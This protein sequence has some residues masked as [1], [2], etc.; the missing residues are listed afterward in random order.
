MH[1]DFQRIQHGD[2]QYYSCKRLSGVRHAFTTKCGGVSKG[3]CE[4]LNLGFNRGDIRES[5]IENYHRLAQALDVPFDHMTMTCQ[6]HRDAISVVTENEVGMGLTRPMAWESDAIITALPNVPLLGYYADCVVTLLHD[7]VKGVAG[8][9]HAGWRGT[10]DNI[11]GKTVDAMVRE[12]GAQRET[13][14]AAIGP[15]IRQCCFETDADVPTA[16][17]TKMGNSVH[18]FIQQRGQK[19]HIDL[20]GINAHCLAEAG[21]AADNSIDSGLC[22]QCHSDIFWSHR[23]TNG[24]RGVQA[25]VICL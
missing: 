25:A 10:A 1:K 15:S 6:V 5:V 9:C 8:V 16:M 18:Q 7:P 12:L 23:A 14:V 13:I 22:T 24:R 3:A 21:V 11:L 20:Q 2:L 19:F 17:E 4:S